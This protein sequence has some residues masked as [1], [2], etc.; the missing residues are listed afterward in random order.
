MAY[1]ASPARLTRFA[2][3]QAYLVAGDDAWR[4][5]LLGLK[6]PLWVALRRDSTMP[7]SLPG[8]LVAPHWPANATCRA[9]L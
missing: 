9:R 5:A 2:Y 3:G 7:P 8:V 4:I 1:V 6:D